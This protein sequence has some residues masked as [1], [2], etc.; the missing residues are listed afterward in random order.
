VSISENSLDA[1][2]LLPEKTS[3]TAASVLDPTFL[4]LAAIL[5]FH[6]GK[7]VAFVTVE[8]YDFH[9]VPPFYCLKSDQ[10]FLL[11]AAF[12]RTTRHAF[13]QSFPPL[14]LQG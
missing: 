10:I 14:L 3:D 8:C 4:Y 1:E 2:R 6:T 13:I 9:S 5:I 12:Y 11:L 7:C